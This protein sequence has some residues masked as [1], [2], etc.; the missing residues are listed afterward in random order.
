MALDT[1]TEEQLFGKGIGLPHRRQQ[2]VA[3]LSHVRKYVF[4]T[5]QQT[6][7]NTAQRIRRQI[8]L[9]LPWASTHGPDSKT[10]W[11]Q[12]RLLES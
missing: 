6:A 11:D 8:A 10:S 5:R 3:Q 9:G 7:S 12:H 2:L 4:L 1:P